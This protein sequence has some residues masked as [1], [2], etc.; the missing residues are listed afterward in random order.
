M[1]ALGFGF[2]GQFGTL[3]T[4]WQKYFPDKKISEAIQS[5]PTYTHYISGF[6]YAVL[7]ATLIWLFIVICDVIWGYLKY[8][9][10]Y[11]SHPFRAI[12]D[13]FRYGYGYYS[14]QQD[15]AESDKDVL[16]NSFSTLGGLIWKV[17]VNYKG[18]QSGAR[19]ILC[20][21]LLT[22]IRSI[23]EKYLADGNTD[24]ENHVLNASYMR[25][26][27]YGNATADQKKYLDFSVDHKEYSYILRLEGYAENNNQVPD[28]FSLPVEKKD[29]KNKWKNFILPGAP[30]A[31]LINDA[32]RISLPHELPSGIKGDFQTQFDAHFSNQQIK[33]F[34]SLPVP[35]KFD[36]AGTN[37][38]LGI[39]TIETNHAR[40]GKLSKIEVEEMT[41]ILNPFLLLLGI[42]YGENDVYE[43]ILKERG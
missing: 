17:I 7:T 43:K 24:N 10:R 36:G 22:S 29:A 1:V 6:L 8:R 18:E 37:F 33:H 11:N 19:K 21:N 25:A 34:I 4:G 12:G 42:L 9:N 15:Q 32:V 27:S 23:S 41:N 20:K 35:L 40:L 38:P 14:I 39:V 30:E 3:L 13:F 5:L 31:L 16:Q 26:I 2:L 28:Y